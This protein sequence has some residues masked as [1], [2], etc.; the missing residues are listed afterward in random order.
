MMITVGQGLSWLWL[1]IGA[2]YL[3]R[4]LI[5]GFFWRTAVGYQGH[6]DYEM[7]EKYLLKTLAIER[8]IERMTGS[9]VGVAHV[10]GSLGFLYHHQRRCDDAAG[11]FG[12][13]LDKFA[14]AG[15]TAARAPILAATGQLYL[16]IGN[17]ELAE[18]HLRQAWAWYEQQPDHHQERQ[19][20][21]AMLD[22]IASKQ[23]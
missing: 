21:Q 13:A 14:I 12:V 3:V 11:M 1:L 6:H 19:T 18:N 22:L 17:Y 23:Q 8:W 20:I 15:R 10:A 7:A 2:L 16:D 5:P 4:K 9:G